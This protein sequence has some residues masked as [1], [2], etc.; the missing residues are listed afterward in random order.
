MTLSYIIVDSTAKQ[1]NVSQEIA[2]ISQTG[3]RESEIDIEE[4][5]L[6]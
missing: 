1:S 6:S 4:K 5:P 2:D 3:V